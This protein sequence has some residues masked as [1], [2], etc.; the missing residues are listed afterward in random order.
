MVRNDPLSVPEKY[1]QAHK[2][3]PLVP[4]MASYSFHITIIKF[5]FLAKED[6]YERRKL[7]LACKDWGFFQKRTTST[8]RPGTISKDT[9]SV[10]HLRGSKTRLGRHESY[11]EEAQK[12]PNELGDNM[13]LF[14]DM[15]RGNL[16]RFHDKTKQVTRMNIYPPYLRP[17]IV[18]GISLHSNLD[19]VT[20]L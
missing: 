6:E 18:L 20:L 12:V 10:C 13:S 3:K 9:A 2:D 4:H 19:I 8:R 17:N 11:S 1:I 16:R 14:M 5:S 7:N 15:A